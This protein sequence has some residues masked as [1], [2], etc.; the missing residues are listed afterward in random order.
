M[1]I[2]D[3]GLAFISILVW[4]LIGFNFGRIARRYYR[5]EKR[6]WPNGK[7]TYAV[8]WVLS[9]AWF[10]GSAFVLGALDRGG[11]FDAIELLGPVALIAAAAASLYC[12]RPRT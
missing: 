12:Y 5:E 9:M 10:I 7:S 1:S 2:A 11:D 3:S 8:D 4:S 6:G